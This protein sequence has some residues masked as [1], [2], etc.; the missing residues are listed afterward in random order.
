LKQR[1]ATVADL[2]RLAAWNRELIEDERSDNPMSLAQLEERMRRW[3]AADYRAVVF[4]S[5]DRPVGYALFRSDEDG[6][7]LRQLLVLRAHRRRGFGREAVRL[8]REEVLPRGVRVWLQVL[9]QNERGLAFW[10]ALGFRPHARTL[11]AP[12]ETE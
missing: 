12:W 2:P 9:E 6:V 7:H 5:D 10:G 1:P 4:E 8:L 11:V 3:L